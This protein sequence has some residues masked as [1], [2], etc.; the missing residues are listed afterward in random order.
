MAGRAR[1]TPYEAQT[2]ADTAS[3]HALLSSQVVIAVPL[4]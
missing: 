4:D 2:T 1:E 3:L